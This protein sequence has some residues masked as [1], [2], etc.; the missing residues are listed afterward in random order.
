MKT[1][2]LFSFFFISVFSNAQ[3]TFQKKFGG[4]DYEYGKAIIQTADSG[5]A[6]IGNTSSFGLT[7]D[8]IYLLKLNANGTIIWSKT[9]GGSLDEEGNSILQTA[10]GD[11]I[12]AGSTSRFANDNKVFLI[13]TN[14]I[15]T[16]IWTNVIGIADEEKAYSVIET[17]IGDLVVSGY[18]P[19]GVYLMKL[20]SSGNLLWAKSYGNNNSNEISSQVIETANGD[21]VMVGKS[22]SVTENL[23]LLRTDMN[24]N[25]LWNKSYG[26]CVG[27]SVLQTSDNGFII[28][29]ETRNANTDIYVLKTDSL[30][31]VLWSKAYGGAS[32]DY[33]E[34]VINDGSGGFM[35]GASTY[36]FGGDDAC[37]LNIDANGNIIWCNTY[38]I[39][40]AAYGE[41]VIATTDGGFAF[42]GE[43]SSDIFVVKTDSLGN[44][45]CNQNSV[46]P[47]VSNYP[48]VLANG[49]VTVTGGNE[50]TLS[51]VTGTPASIETVICS[52]T[53]VYENRNDKSILIYPNP[54]STQTV[55]QTENL[56]HNATLT[57]DNCFGQT[58]AQ[59]KHISGQTVVLSRDNLPSGLYFIRLTEDNKTLT[60][61]K[62]I[63]T[64]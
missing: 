36:S 37:L 44:S 13:R 4:A 59:I 31:N 54:F 42:C 46:L 27:K 64:D 24:G 41:C 8:D 10:N 38:G 49:A 39:P 3:I 45:G 16:I 5:F 20:N 29:G 9:Y 60:T 30:G 47:S 58:V 14:N 7:S 19:D 53:A 40:G 12:I 63:I 1:K 32:S 18:T 52:N 25:L 22:D 50:F 55:L 57:V 34:S 21:Y 51:A 33:A 6:V 62:L 43:L 48:V 26:S 35:I 61:D 28:S 15:G 23:F 2:L 56:L 11:F 17:S